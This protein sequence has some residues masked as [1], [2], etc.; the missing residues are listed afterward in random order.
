VESGVTFFDTAD[1]YGTGHS[2]TVLGRALA[3]HRSDVVLASKWGNTFDEATRTMT[4]VDLSPEYVRRA[5]VAS[6]RRL[7][8]GYLDVYQLHISDA[9]T[10]DGARLRDACEEL[11]TEGLIRA[12]AWST[13]D[14]ERAAVFATGRQCAAV[15]HECSV[16][17][18]APELLALCDAHDMASIARSPLAMG[19]LT[20]KYGGQERPGAGDIRATPPGWLRYFVDGAASPAWLARIEAVRAVLT[21][22]GRSLAQGSLAWLW[23]RSPRTIPIPGFRTLAQVRENVLAMDHGPLRPEQRDE[24]TKLLRD[25]DSRIV[26]AEANLEPKRLG[27]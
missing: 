7:G 6:L 24:I 9:S 3:G 17:H 22:G 11:V 13:D 4:G 5:L 21:S 15:Q 20:G 27:Y 14:P 25:T 1:V 12:Y 10:D 19:L 16:L 8:T 23:A 26:E 18:D 2:E